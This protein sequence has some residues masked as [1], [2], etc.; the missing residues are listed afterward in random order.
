MRHLSASIVGCLL[1]CL[2][3]STGM[4]AWAQ[5]QDQPESQNY[6][7][8]NYVLGS[9]GMMGA[10]SS[11]KLH[12]ATAGEEII[13]GSSSA[14]YFLIAGFW[15]AEDF[16]PTDVSYPENNA[17]PARFQLR[18]N[19]P[20]PFNPQTTIEYALP[21]ESRV[22]IEI[23]NLTGQKIRTLIDNSRQGPGYIQEIWDSR[24]D[25]GGLVGS[26]CYLFR[27]TVFSQS[28]TKR[29]GEIL[30]QQTQ[31]MLFIK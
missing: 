13:N 24:D 10:S 18:Q 22:N 29:P 31:K 23:Y 27:L 9:G 28:T 21:F 1:L 17:I 30:F 12:F 16:L 7:I 8:T 2:L 3:C 14:N 25:S 4:V 19:F 20:N 11:G 5:P 6:L 26:G 15:A